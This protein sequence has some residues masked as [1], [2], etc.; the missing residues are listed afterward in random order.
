MSDFVRN[1]CNLSFR[2][3]RMTAMT[4]VARETSLF[5]RVHGI[6]FRPRPPAEARALII[7]KRLL[8]FGARV[9]DD[10]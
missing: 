5:A 4:R 9:I 3:E 1:Q 6:V 8:N 10:N 7:E 2:I